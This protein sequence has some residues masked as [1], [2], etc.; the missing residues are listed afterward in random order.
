MT[1]YYLAKGD[2]ESAGAMV[3]EMERIAPTNEATYL[4]R[5]YLAALQGDKAT[6]M[7]MIA[8]LDATHEP[9]WSMSSSAG[10]IY[11]AL[12]DLDKFFEYMFTAVRDHTLQLANICYSPLLAGARKDP[13]FGQI[14]AAVR[15]AQQP[16]S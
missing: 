3:K 14:V 15:R 7:E 2:L 12:G 11:L 9:G 10:F 1:D 5:G 8:K 16:A 13:R 4:N 6:A